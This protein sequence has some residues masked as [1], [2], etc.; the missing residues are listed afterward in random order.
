MLNM[1]LNHM[2]IILLLVIAVLAVPC[3]GVFAPRYL[4]RSLA[5]LL[6][7]L[8]MMVGVA[9]FLPLIAYED[10]WLVGTDLLVLILTPLVGI[11]A[12][13]RPHHRSPS[14]RSIFPAA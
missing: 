5:V 12:I 10:G 7:A 14:R 4:L 13:L 11:I 2:H 3:I 9:A 1:V 6:L 8:V